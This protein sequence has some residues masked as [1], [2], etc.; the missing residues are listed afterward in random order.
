MKV[1]IVDDN[2][3]TRQMMKLHLGGLTDEM[4]ECE[5]GDEALAAYTEFLPDCVL[6]DWEMRRVDG[7]TATRLI[8]A[9]FP[10]AHILFVTQYD[11][12]ELRQAA[13]EA[14][15]H[16]FVAKDDLLCLRTLLEGSAGT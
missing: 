10:E 16:G 13:R 6:M 5:D 11:D 1:L 3:R 7:L 8:L 9:R 15:A 12:A 4:R 2:R 14:G